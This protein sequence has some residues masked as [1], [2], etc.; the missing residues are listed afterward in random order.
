MLTNEKV[1][2]MIL[3]GLFEELKELG[4]EVV[5]SEAGIRYSFSEDQRKKV[6]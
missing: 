2:E 6:K 5:F 4:V 1:E 3:E